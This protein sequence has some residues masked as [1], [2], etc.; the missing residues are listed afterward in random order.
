MLESFGELFYPW[1]LLVSVKVFHTLI[2]Q[3]DRS[4]NDQQF[5]LK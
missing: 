5:K 3:I 1:G 4:Q 2:L